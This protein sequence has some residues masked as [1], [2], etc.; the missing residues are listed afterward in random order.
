[1]QALS[2]TWEIIATEKNGNM[3]QSWAPGGG[4]ETHSHL[5]RARSPSRT[6]W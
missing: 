3:S 4:N 5:A 2:H 1:M 6:T